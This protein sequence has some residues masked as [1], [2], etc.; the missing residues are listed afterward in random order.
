[1]LF[2]FGALCASCLSAANAQSYNVYVDTNT[3]ASSPNGD[4][5]AADFNLLQDPQTNPSSGV[6]SNINLG[7]GSEI[8]PGG[9]VVAT[10]TA[11][12]DLSSA[13]SLS[14]SSGSTAAEFY[15]DFV[16]GSSLSFT[17]DSAGFSQPPNGVGASPTQFSFDIFDD[18]NPS[19]QISLNTADNGTFVS[20]ALDDTGSE[21]WTP[22]T[23]T[24]ELGNSNILVTVTPIAAAPEATSVVS[25]ALVI[26][27]LALIMSAC[28]FRNRRASIE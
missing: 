3:L 14:T 18:N 10:G 26:A 2:L 11:A 25:M 27:V 13:I 15:Q 1:M 23:Y 20:I 24:D 17:V 19:N 8:T 5:F 6:V 16:P 4:I 12:G 28:S 21:T 7:G 9:G 22:Y